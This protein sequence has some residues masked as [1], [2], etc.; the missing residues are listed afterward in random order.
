MQAAAEGFP[1]L[2]AEDDEKEK[3][4]TFK[5]LLTPSI[6]GFVTDD[7]VAAVAASLSDRLTAD[8]SSGAAPTRIEVVDCPEGPGKAALRAAA[9]A[10]G[11][12]ATAVFKNVAAMPDAK[13]YIGAVALRDQVREALR[14]LLDESGADAWA[15][16]AT[17]CLPFEHNPRQRKI[18]ILVGGEEQEV[19]YWTAM[20]PYIQAASVAGTPVVTVPAGFADGGGGTNSVACTEQEMADMALPLP[21]GMQ[22]IGRRGEDEALL[23]CAS[24]FETV[25]WGEDSARLPRPSIG[26]L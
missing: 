6:P 18:P 9:I 22:L 10:Y 5:I 19:G 17:S 7:R 15:V 3:E 8:S 12:F 26:E 20:L 13:A 2:E 24:A 25:L 23:R 4:K 21:V 14:S 11:T 1:T 16:P